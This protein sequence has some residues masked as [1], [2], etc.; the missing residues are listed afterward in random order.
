MKIGVT[1]LLV[2]GRGVQTFHVRHVIQGTGRDPS[3]DPGPGPGPGPG[4]LLLGQL[5]RELPGAGKRGAALHG[6]LHRGGGGGVGPVL[7]L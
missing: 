2:G 5:A 7:E 6:L 1:D 4:S 3:F